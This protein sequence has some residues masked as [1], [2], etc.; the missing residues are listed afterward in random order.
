MPDVLEIFVGLIMEERGHKEA[1]YEIFDQDH[2]G[3]E[4]GKVS[5]DDL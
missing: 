1:F 4:R 2:S 5:W 3:R